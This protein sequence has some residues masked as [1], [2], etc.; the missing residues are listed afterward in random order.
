MND[1]AHNEP[2]YTE[3]QLRLK[4][5]PDLKRNAHIHAITKE[6]EKQIGSSYRS[7]IYLTPAAIVYL[8]KNQIRSRKLPSPNCPATTEFK[9]AYMALCVMNYST[10]YNPYPT[11]EML[12]AL[13]WQM[14]GRVTFLSI[15]SSSIH[16]EDLPCRILE[17]KSYPFPS[18]SFD[19]KEV[20]IRRLLVQN[21]GIDSRV[22]A[23]LTATIWVN[24]Y[25]SHWPS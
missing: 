24:W 4:V 8:Y 11:D 22:N 9:R 13:F 25:L 5:T 14:F 20:P 10:P 18:R 6:A 2:P 19:K 7:R 23:S 12:P 16:S 17:W 3:R 1:H 21:C 15:P